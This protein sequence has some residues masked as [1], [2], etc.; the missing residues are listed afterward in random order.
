M[1]PMTYTKY[2]GL[3]MAAITMAKVSMP[4]L[5]KVKGWLCQIDQGHATYPRLSSS[6]AM[7]SHS[8]I[9]IHP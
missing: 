4:V 7:E 3:N 2:F 6:K 1:H 5:Q 9:V 8:M